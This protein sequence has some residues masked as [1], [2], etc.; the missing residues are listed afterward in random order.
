M[1]CGLESNSCMGIHVHILKKYAATP[2]PL[3]L[4]LSPFFTPHKNFADVNKIDNTKQVQHGVLLKCL[5]L[6]KPAQQILN[7]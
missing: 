6:P 7:C 2:R 5:H 3:S 1:L 4:P